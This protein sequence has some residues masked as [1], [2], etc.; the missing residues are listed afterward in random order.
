MTAEDVL[1]TIEVGN[2][3]GL[4][5]RSTKGVMQMVK[6]SGPMMSMAA[7]G[8]LAGTIVFSKWKGRPYV[9]SLVRPSNP[10]SGG[11]VG[12]RGMFK[13]L[14]QN[15]TN[16]SAG[17]KATWEARAEQKVV[18]PFNA[19]MSLNQARFRDFTPPTEADPAAESASPDTAA[20]ISAALGVR[21]ITITCVPAAANAN[22]GGAFFRSLSSS[23]VPSFDNL[24]GVVLDP[25][26]DDLIWIDTPLVPD[27]YYY[28][29]KMFTSDGLWVANSNEV[30][31]TVV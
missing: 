6:V 23:V 1:A 12:V 5:Q 3:A 21:S 19:F 18:S 10:K 24:I 9:R 17:N 30:D 14:A 26:G 27:T 16:V 25:G 20:T 31:E 7:T 2:Y 11:Q 28:M 8:K 4:R 29:N 15:W 22:W 13:Y